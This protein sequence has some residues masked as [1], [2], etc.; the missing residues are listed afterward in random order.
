VWPYGLQSLGSEYLEAISVP[1]I[2]SDPLATNIHKMLVSKRRNDWADGLTNS[3]IGDA[4]DAS[5]PTG[6]ETRLLSA[7][8][9]NSRRSGGQARY[10]RG[11]SSDG[12]GIKVQKARQTTVFTNTTED[13]S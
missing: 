3:V 8:D 1:A 13:P 9:M 4:M 11:G 10:R 7:T 6:K 2:V 12:Y 5:L